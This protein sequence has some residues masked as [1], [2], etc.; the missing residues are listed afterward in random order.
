[1]TAVTAI[2]RHLAACGPLPPKLAAL[3]T[4]GQ[5]AVLKIVR[6]EVRTQGSCRLP[7]GAIAAR[8]GVCVT[9]ARDTIRFA[10]D[11]GLLTHVGMNR[12]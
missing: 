11:E 3:F 10:A 8:A 1:M 2:P 7:L 5:L 6:D 12:S 9:T 4:T